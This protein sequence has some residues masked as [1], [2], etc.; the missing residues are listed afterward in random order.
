MSKEESQ[1]YYVYRYSVEDEYVFISRLKNLKIQYYVGSYHCAME[2]IH[3]ITG[4][5]CPR[6]HRIKAQ[7]TRKDDK[8]T[9]SIKSNKI[10]AK[11]K[12]GERHEV[13]RYYEERFL[14]ELK[15]N[16]A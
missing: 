5:R 12:Q 10:T 15:Y 14:A 16:T 13:D 2:S 8:I 3:T 4:K 6:N 7:G 11:K 1:K 9:W